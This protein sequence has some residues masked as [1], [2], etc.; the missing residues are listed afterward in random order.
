MP[1][2][3]PRWSEADVTKHNANLAEFEENSGRGI[4]AATLVERARQAKERGLLNSAFPKR[5]NKFGAMATKV[6]GLRFDSK[7]EAKRYR[8]LVLLQKSGAISYFLRQV[9]FMLPGGIRYRVD[10]QIFYRHQDGVRLGPTTGC[11]QVVE[12][13][14]CKGHQDRTGI[15]KIRQVEDIYGITINLV[16]S[17]RG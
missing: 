6:D 15:N 16:K 11:A 13:E 8:E 3:A 9:A 12:Y 2:K 1:N 10:F 7:L 4:P 17:A 5:A 14:D